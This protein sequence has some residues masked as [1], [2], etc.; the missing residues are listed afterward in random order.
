[1]ASAPTLK[2]S[3]PIMGAAVLAVAVL[4]L[5]LIV[6]AAYHGSSGSTGAQCGS[7]RGVLGRITRDLQ[8]AAGGRATPAD[9][10]ALQRDDDDLNNFLNAGQHPGL[11]AHL[12]PVAENLGRA[13]TDLRD[14][15]PAQTDLGALESA[16]AGATT[17]C[18]PS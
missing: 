18:G 12:L 3:R 15:A 6:A 10:A 16:L 9:V 2:L 1:M 8:P 11:D 14:A 7:V 4:I 13:V 5:V 17:F